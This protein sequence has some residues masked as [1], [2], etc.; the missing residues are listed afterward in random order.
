MIF[1]YVFSNANYN[2]WMSDKIYYT[3]RDRFPIVPTRL[4]KM[5]KAS[6][7][8]VVSSHSGS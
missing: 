5:L 1:I 6:K 4:F 7:I 2:L 8:T 3:E